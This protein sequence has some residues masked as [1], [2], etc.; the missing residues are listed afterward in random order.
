MGL[1]LVDVSNE[2]NLKRQNWGTNGAAWWTAGH[3]LCLEGICTNAACVANGQY[4]IMPVGFV[5]FNVDTE[6][7]TTSSASSASNTPTRPKCPMCLQY[8]EPKKYAFNNCWW[9]FTGVKEN[10]VPC[11]SDWHYADNAYHRFDDDP[12]SKIIWYNLILEAVKDKPN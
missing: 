3:G 12:N 1:K 11:S 10:D 4:V 9:R 8:V 5:K 2:S 6:E 7:I